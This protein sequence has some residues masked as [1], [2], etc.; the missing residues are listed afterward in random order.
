[1]CADLESVCHCLFYIMLLMRFGLN[2][3]QEQIYIYIYIYRISRDKYLIVSFTV[4][5]YTLTCN[6]SLSGDKFIQYTGGLLSV[7]VC[8]CVGNRGGQLWHS[9]HP[10]IKCVIVVYRTSVVLGG[11]AKS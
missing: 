5:S 7:C 8:V 1:M 10:V 9:K 3:L 2:S 6:C 4:L 11:C